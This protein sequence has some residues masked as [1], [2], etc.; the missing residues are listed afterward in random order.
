[1]E[2]VRNTAID[3]AKGLATISVVCAHCNGV[4]ITNGIPRI[5]SLILQHI[6]T[7]GV[8]VFFFISGMLYKPRRGIT[9]LHPLKRIRKLILPWIFSGTM[10]YLYVYLRKPPMSLFGYV[11]FLLG[12]G[13]YLYYPMLA[14]M[15]QVFVWPIMRNKLVLYAY[16]II[17]AYV[18][19]FALDIP[20]L[21]PYLN[22]FSWIGYFAL[23]ILC[24]QNH[25]GAARVFA[26]LFQWQWFVHAITVTLIT[27]MVLQDRAGSYWGGIHTVAAWSGALSILLLS[28]SMARVRFLQWAG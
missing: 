20:R 3:V 11:A 10:V 21:T 9:V 5:G 4:Y 17:T 27:V 19:V 13:S 18:S 1:M 26:R 2:N 7:Y 15:Y 14:C 6:G 16:I 22:I 12:N 8:L 28:R 23:G 24:G 25:D